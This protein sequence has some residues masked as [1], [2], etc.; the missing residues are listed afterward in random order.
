[1][2]KK[3]C[4]FYLPYPLSKTG[5]RARQLRPRKMLMAFREMGYSIFLVQ[6]YSDKRKK[7]ITMLK[8]LIGSGV[9]FDFMYGECNTE[10]IRLSDPDHL[11]KHPL[12]DFRFFKYLKEQGIPVGLFY[13]DVFWK[14]PV[15]RESLPFWKREIALH[16]YRS[17]LKSFAGVLDRLFIP[18]MGMGKYLDAPGIDSI[19]SALPPGGDPAELPAEKKYAERD[20]SEE[21]M[22]ILYVGGIQNHY[23]M[24]KLF[25]ALAGIPEAR[26]TVCTREEEWEQEKERLAPYIT[27][28]VEII[29][30]NADELIPYYKKADIGSLIFEPE[31]YWEM[32]QPVK[33]YEYLSYGLPVLATRGTAVGS[34][35]ERTGFG[36][37][38]DCEAEV[39]STWIR[40]ILKHPEWLE[41]KRKNAEKAIPDNL[42][43]SRAKQAAEELMS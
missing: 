3:N 28:R 42:W 10:P 22:E 13:G 17:E 41:E 33:A 40:A 39:I 11:P 20:F 1:M 31:E 43:L 25:A 19:I 8:E 29:H 36:W 9:T 18:D 32:A 6:G 24:D 12:M 7:R 37:T 23:R 2:G 14:F 21:P 38:L 35:V 15:Y 5:N 34:F 16:Y 26:L 30:K 4:I 27:D